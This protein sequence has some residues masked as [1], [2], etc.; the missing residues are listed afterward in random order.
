MKILSIETS[1]DETAISI[2]EATSP[3]L[4]EEGVGGG[5]SPHFK[6]LGNTVATQIELHAQYGGVFPMM[7]KRE[8]SKN[9]IPVL[10]ETLK[11]SGMYEINPSPTLPLAGAGETT[12]QEILTREPELLE[13]CKEYLPH[14]SKPNIDVIVVTS[15]PGLEPALWVGINFA[16]VLG[17]LWNIPV[18]PVNHMEGHIM[19]PILTTEGTVNVA[20]PALALLI[21]GGHTEL[22]VVNNWMDYKKIGQTRDDAVGEAFDKVARMMDLPYPGG[23]QIS[24]LAEEYRSF[25]PLDKGEV[26]KAEGVLETKNPSPT[27]PLSRKGDSYQIILPRPMLHSNDY[28]FSFSGLKTAVLYAIQDIKKDGGTLTDDIKKQTAC[29]FENAATEV[30]LTKTFKAIDE[31]GIQTLLIGGGVA[32]NKFIKKS[33]LEKQI[34]EYPNLKILLPEKDLSTDN[35]LMIAIAGY[36]RYQQIM[37]GNKKFPLDFVANGNWD[38]SC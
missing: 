35:A 12:I 31:Y 19:S 23:P 11:K 24:K 37:S 21:S 27:L 33:F 16:K 3:L 13:I 9:I 28:D 10:I 18:V 7:A 34:A 2:V 15:G 17:T 22:V 14:I 30:L 26:P 4:V 1:C 25:S 6:I 5:D 36:Y 32:A 29:E 38:V 20:F 8:H